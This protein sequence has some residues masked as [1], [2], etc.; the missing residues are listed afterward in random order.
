VI[1][2]NIFEYLKVKLFLNAVC[3]QVIEEIVDDFQSIVLIVLWPVLK[4]NLSLYL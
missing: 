2:V 1:E 3:T 4:V